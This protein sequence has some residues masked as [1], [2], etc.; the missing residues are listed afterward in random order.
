[1]NTSFFYAVDHTGEKHIPIV[2]TTKED[3]RLTFKKEILENLQSLR[4]LPELA[5]AKVGDDGFFILPRNLEMSGDLMV[6]FLPIE[7]VTYSYKSPIMSC[8][9]FK[10]EAGAALVRMERNYKYAFCVSVQNG[11]YTAEVVFDFTKG[12]PV[13]DDIRMEVIP[14][15]A[16]ATLGD[17]AAA[18]RQLRLDRGEIVPLAEKCK[19]E[20][21]EYARNWPLVRIRLGWKQS[22]NPVLHQTPENEPEMHVAVTFARVRD[23]ADAL[24]TQGVAGAELQLVGWNKSGHDGRYP[25]LMPP[26]EKLG[27]MEELKKTIAYVKALGYRISLHTNSVDAVE[28][29]DCFTWDDVVLKR[30]GSYL[31]TGH[32]SAGYSY[33][34][35]PEKQLKNVM[36]DLPEVAQLE[37]NGL[38]YTDVISIILPDTCFSKDHPCYTAKGI[39]MIRE[40]MRYTRELFGGFS[41]EGCMD[42][43]LKELDFGLYVSLGDGMGKTQIPVTQT[44]VPFFELTYHGILL[45]NPTS[46]TV[47]YP[48][49]TP[50]DKLTFR[51]RG[52]RPSFYIHSK[53]R[54]GEPNWMG[55]V[56]LVASDNGSLNYA[57]QAIADSIRENEDLRDLQLVYMQDYQVLENGIEIVTYADGTRMIGNFNRQEQ[58]Y[59]GHCLPPFGYVVLR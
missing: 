24:K 37:L 30:D 40:N 48:I 29:A 18:E 32:Y 13:Y 57:A 51:M 47:N 31:Q 9:G 52:G 20:A 1:M 58:I 50:A 6:R 22:P 42:F 5:K 19:R 59:E 46:P 8:Y 49:K 23:I 21:V 43:A 25:Q 36:R 53:F 35:C 38:H 12:D 55:D 27:G 15:Q 34:V 41:S 16:D 45:Y 26:E 10:T 14:M 2:E 44:L 17:F 3:Y 33:H 4:V 54:Y 56:D 39:R 11:V 28:V 7:D